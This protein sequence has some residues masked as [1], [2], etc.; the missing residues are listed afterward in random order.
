[1][2]NRN[3]YIEDLKVI[4]RVM[5][6][7]SRFLSLSGLSGLF[8]GLIALAGAVVA[9]YLIPGGKCLI[10]GSA[11][12]CTAPGSLKASLA[13]V[14]AI[15]VLLAL[16]VAL[17]FSRR[18]AARKGL[19]MWT[20]TSQRM[21]VNLFVPMVTGGVLII[22]TAHRGYYEAIIPFM[23]VFYGLG[24]VNAGKFTYGEIF[25]LGLIEITAGL[26]AAIFSSFALLF[27]CTGF[28][29]LHIVY[30]SIMYRKYER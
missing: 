2:D 4:K 18:N 5:E 25:W 8:I 1:M 22:I 24:L 27:W 15:V 10:P 11:E 6:E 29:I 9:V 26:L 19:K 7:S 3:D 16:G 23:L 20:S 30:G 12:P 14:S 21:L 17:W 28:G 13:I